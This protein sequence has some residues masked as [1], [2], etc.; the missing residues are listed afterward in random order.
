MDVVKVLE[1]LES[2]HLIRLNKVV[3]KYY[4]IYCPFHND[5]QEK[6]PSCGVLLETEYRNGVT[7]KAG[8][9]HCF[10]CQYAKNLPDMISDLLKLH[11]IS[12]SGIE[13]LKANVPGFNED[14]EEQDDLIS[15]SLYNSVNSSFAVNYIAELSKLDTPKYISE[16]ELASYRYTVPYMY[17]RKLTDDLIEKFDVGFDQNWTPPGRKNKVPCITFPVRD[18]SGNTLFFVRRSVKGKFFNM[19]YDVQKPV[20]GLYELPE[21]CRSVIV[22]ESCLNAI[23]CYRYGKP[24][25]AL[26]GTGTPY[27][28]QQLKELGAQEFILGFDPDDAGARATRKLKR[29]L[30]DVAIV[31]SYSNIPL[32]KDINDL[33]EEEFNS[34]ELE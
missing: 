3:G 20:Y 11:H 23:T 9:T 12:S 33:T 24:A 16:E 15:P 27:Q 29:A 8:F 7:Y 31:W 2:E 26:L 5:G 25:V 19:P 22:V 21:G 13:W 28:I 10:T 17:E 30:K 32:N 1:K 6:K 14:K 4:S 18:R 34:L